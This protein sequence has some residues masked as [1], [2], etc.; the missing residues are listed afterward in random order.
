[1]SID[2]SYTIDTFCAVED[3]SRGMLYKLWKVGKGPRF[4]YVGSRRHISHEARI[5]WRQGLEAEAEARGRGAIAG[6]AEVTDATA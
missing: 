6:A 1:M 4:Y 5:E 2:P 3:M